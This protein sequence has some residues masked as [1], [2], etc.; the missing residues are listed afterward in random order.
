MK[1]SVFTSRFPV[2]D[3]NIV[4]CLRPCNV[5]NFPHLNSA[6]SQ[7]YFTSGGSPWLKLI[8]TQDQIFFSI[9]PLKAEFLNKFI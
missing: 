7:S 1:S 2:M 9:D 5:A 6:Q 3:L 4:L 8:E